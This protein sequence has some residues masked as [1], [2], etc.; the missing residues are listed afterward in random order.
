MVIG[1]NVQ[2]IINDFI[3]DNCKYGIYIV[4]NIYPIP[5]VTSISMNRNFFI[6]LNAF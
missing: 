6:I 1:A 5:L 4:F 2:N 3:I